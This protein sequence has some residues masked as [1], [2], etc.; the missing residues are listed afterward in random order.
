MLHMRNV[1][2]RVGATGFVEKAGTA[3]AS[4]SALIS[5]FVWTK[6]DNHGLDSVDAPS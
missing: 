6:N 1:S 5:D 3:Q 2:F 4:I